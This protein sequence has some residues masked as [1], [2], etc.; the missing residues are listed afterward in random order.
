MDIKRKI[1][2]QKSE[3][4]IQRDRAQAGGDYDDDDDGKTKKL[5]SHP[6]LYHEL[7]KFPVTK[8]SILV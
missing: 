5:S 1:K 8:A 4:E 3:Y 7:H 6:L 2:S